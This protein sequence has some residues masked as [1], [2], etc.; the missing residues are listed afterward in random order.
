MK[1]SK[2]MLVIMLAIKSSA[3]SINCDAVL[4]R[5]TDPLTSQNWAK[6]F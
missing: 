5:K 4:T 1:S 2:I 3:A 6:S